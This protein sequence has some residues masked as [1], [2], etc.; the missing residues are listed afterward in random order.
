MESKR[1]KLKKF[2]K[3]GGTI[4]GL[5]SLTKFGIYRLS[6]VIHVWRNQGIEID[7]EMIKTNNSTYARYKFK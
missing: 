3:K 5:T 6:D 7:T 1:S 4:T 2:M